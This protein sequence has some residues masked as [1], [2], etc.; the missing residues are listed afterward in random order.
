M[1][2]GLQIFNEGKKSN[3]NQARDMLT[4]KV[5]SKIKDDSEI[6]IFVNKHARVTFVN[7]LS[8]QTN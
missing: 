1:C 3:Q 5:D 7:R 8:H 2:K 6:I 4:I